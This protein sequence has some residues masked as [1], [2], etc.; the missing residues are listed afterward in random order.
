V[1]MP[2]KREEPDDRSGGTVRR[3]TPLLAMLLLA[4]GVVTRAHAEPPAPTYTYA[5][6][7][8]GVQIAL[9]VAFPTGFDPADTTTKWPAL[10]E[11]DGYEGGA[12]P[13][14][15]A[16]WGDHYVTIHASLRGTGCSGGAFDLFSA[17]SAQD[18]HDIIDGWIANQPWSN[19]DVGIIGHSYPG[20]T[21]FWVAETQPLHLRAV[22][23][24][25]LIDDLYRGI[26]YP[27]G[28]SNPGFPLLWTA[29]ARPAA[30][31]FGNFPRYSQG[32]PVCAA[33]IATR[34]APA[35]TDDPIV[36]G[37][38][39][40]EDGVWWQAHS[41]I[42]QIDKI[43]VPIHITQQYQDEQTGPR[44]GP[45]LWQRLPASVP[46][47][48]VLTNGV[49]A[50]NFIAHADKNA[51]L[52]C[53]ILLRGQAC[54]GDIADPTRRVQV[55]FETTGSGNDPEKDTVNPAY[56][57]SDFPLPE[58]VWQRLYFHGD[59]TLSTAT[60][61]VG[62]AGRT[63]VATPEGRAGYASGAGAADVFGSGAETT[64]DGAY[65]QD[66]GP[67]TTSSG[68]DQVSYSLDLGETTAT[69]AGPID[70]DLWAT[71]TAPDTDFFVQLID[72]DAAGNYSYLQRGMLRA[73]FRA[74]DDARS[75]HTPAGDVYRPYHPF[76]KGTTI[77]PGDAYEYEIEVFPLGHVLRAGHR[78]L[79]QVYAPPFADELNA[80]GSGQPPAANT[81][82]SDPDHQSSILL[83]L[84]PTLP[85]IS[86][87]PPGCGDQTGIRCT[88]PSM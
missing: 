53:W 13:V 25:G 44:G 60:P 71:S 74:F 10:F 85:P 75:D 18:G 6:M 81:I 87:T 88:K 7:N 32:D 12:L 20:L 28:I 63:Y 21:G 69:I 8:D 61:S 5:T 66:Y 42:T 67:V 46:K 11:M 82:L 29:L 83:P 65:A 35:A 86:Q 3:V 19:G 34:G 59:G 64:L 52:D 58:T 1:A 24:S 41:L 39:N 16:S 73:S 26:T 70:V 14:S 68:P 38:A 48:L 55:H 23:V 57:S 72:V 76:T 54:P 51:W 50:T 45:M 4:L 78:L 30:E 27:G 79:V 9:A 84:L 31:E 17:R 47:R 40:R 15:P 77:T 80:Y 43:D 22:A 49:H 37:T 56:V 2:N 62:D 36:N 33:N